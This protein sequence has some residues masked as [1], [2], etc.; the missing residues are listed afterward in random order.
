MIFALLLPACTVTI[1]SGPPTHGKDGGGRPDDTDSAEVIPGDTSKDSGHGEDTG[2]TGSGGPDDDDVWRAF[3]DIRTVQEIE[4]ELTAEAIATLNGDGH[5]YVT[6]NVVING[7]RY[8]DV[9]VRLK[10]SSTYETFEYCGWHSAPCKPSFKVKLDE[11][12]PDQKL[13]DM[14]RLTFNN[15][16]YDY[17][18]AKETIDYRA[19]EE[20]GMTVPK[21]NYAHILV[22]G[23]NFGLYT[24]LESMDDEW[25]KH[26]YNDATGDLWGTSPSYG[27]FTDSGM[28][29]GWVLK[30]GEGDKTALSAVKRALDTYSGD[31][32]NDF[33][34]VIDTAQFLDYW[35]W[36]IAVGNQDGYP[37]HSNDV[38]LYG[39]PDD[40]GRF[41][42]SPWGMDEAWD[43]TMT[44]DGAGCR[45]GY[46][47]SID[48]NCV[49][50]LK[51]RS[52]AAISAYEKMDVSAF[53]QESFDVSQ[54]Y[55][56][57]DPR[58]PF[59]VSD[60]EAYRAYLLS[61]IDFWPDRMRSQ[62]GI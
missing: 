38:F 19:W 27:D 24:N 15:M 56:M 46:A 32:F 39:D 44:W 53:A 3:Y 6:G 16:T 54:A 25:L 61:Q 11:F 4:I 50:E 2:D 31:F 42:F 13:G 26:R 58:R 52:E 57:E 60:V 41:D 5:S 12:V 43:E 40:G 51:T 55:M 48:A 21:S 59:T 30:S 10:G 33:D 35:A 36:N 9:G 23:E 29:G 34:P 62:M 28:R 8:D 49:S 17:T 7:E 22:N 37:F 1:P 47:C 18:Q 45:L 20:G 14:Q